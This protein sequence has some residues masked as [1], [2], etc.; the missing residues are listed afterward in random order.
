MNCAGMGG[1]LDAVSH[2]E[3]GLA[4]RSLVSL[5][6]TS[7][8]I[9]SAPLDLLR[10]HPVVRR[11]IAEMS[12]EDRGRFVSAAIL[13]LPAP[14]CDHPEVVGTLLEPMLHTESSEV[15]GYAAGNP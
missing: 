3:G 15:A 2:Q 6:A 9:S 7:G 14:F 10:E 12:S 13:A 8:C 1:Y 4:A 5:I 11:T